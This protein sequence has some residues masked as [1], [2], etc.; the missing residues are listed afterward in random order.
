MSCT[1]EQTPTIPFAENAC[2]VRPISS[3]ERRQHPIDKKEPLHYMI[4]DAE[5]DPLALVSGESS[6]AFR[7]ARQKDHVPQWMH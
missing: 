4:V 7:F 6:L 5:G 2:F 1:D 3:Q